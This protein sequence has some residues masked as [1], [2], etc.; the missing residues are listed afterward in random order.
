[1]F[2][3]WNIPQIKCLLVPPSQERSK[4]PRFLMRF[5]AP[6]QDFESL[7]SAL[8]EV[9]SGRETELRH[10]LPENWVFFWK[11]REGESRLLL[12]HPEKQD[13]VATLALTPSHADKVLSSLR[14]YEK[15]KLSE[16]ETVGSFSNVE[17]EIS[18]TDN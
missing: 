3:N 13:W 16:L 14:K 10:N 12:A 6:R 11:I 15:F 8:E 17:I 4:Q 5:S 7:I 2:L 18:T 9:F 1:M